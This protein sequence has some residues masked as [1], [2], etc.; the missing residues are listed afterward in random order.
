MHAAIVHLCEG[1]AD[2]VARGK[3]THPHDEPAA[4]ARKQQAAGENA[5]NQHC[6]CH[7]FFGAAAGF[8]CL[9]YFKGEGAG[10]IVG[11][12]TAT[13]GNHLT[14]RQLIRSAPFCE[15]AVGRVGFIGSP[16]VVDKDLT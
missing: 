9:G 6:R 15:S 11:D 7:G 2:P 10:F 1:A 4:H 8:P 13:E 16:R 12:M 14:G 3:Q 5:A